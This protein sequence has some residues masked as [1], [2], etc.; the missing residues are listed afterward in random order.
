M[1]EKKYSKGLFITEYLKS[2]SPLICDIN[3]LDIIHRI[4]VLHT[5]NLYLMTLSLMSL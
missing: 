2:T 1:A 4:E 5:I 3:K